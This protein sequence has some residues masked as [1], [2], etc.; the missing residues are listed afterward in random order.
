VIG[1]LNSI[2]AQKNY[3]LGGIVSSEGM[4]DA[5]AVNVKLFHDLAHPSVLFVPIGRHL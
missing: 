1:P 2:Y 3:N 4:Q 5:V